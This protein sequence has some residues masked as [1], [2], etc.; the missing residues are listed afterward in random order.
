M[1]TKCWSEKPDRKRPLGR[2]RLRWEDNIKIDLREMG[3]K[4]M[5]WIHL[6]QDRNQWRDLVKTVMNFQIS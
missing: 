1:Y 5:D 4:I 6:S 3:W 2:L